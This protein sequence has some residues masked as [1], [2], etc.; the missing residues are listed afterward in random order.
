MVSIIIPNY[1]KFDLLEKCI[2]S[3]LKQNYTDIE[4][5]VVDNGSDNKDSIVC[6]ESKVKFIW[7]DKN[8]G[9]SKAVNIGIK[10]AKGNFLAIINN[11]TELTP[12]WINNILKAFKN[13][14]N[15][16]FITSKILSLNN[17]RIIDDVGDVILP[18]GKVYKIG[19]GEEDC[20][21][22]NNSRKIFGASGAASVYKREFFDIVGYFDEDFFAYLEDID[23]SFRANHFGLK[24]MYAPDAV[25]YH[26]GS[27]TTG[28]KFNKFT[29]YYLAQNT[30]NVIAK[31]FPIRVLIRYFPH[32]LSH[33]LKLQLYFSLNRLG[34]T[35]LKGLISGI[36]MINTMAK[37]RKEIMKNRR[38]PDS[39][40]ITMLKENKRLYIKSKAN[41]LE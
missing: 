8:E 10:Y 12:D 15:V 29:V 22:Y 20:G 30:I 13:N 23:L 32:I 21:Q 6:E 31:N 27:A 3:I 1:N 19:N 40:L 5:I 39:E 18:S 14:E 25:V 35:F 24:G 34:F 26:V 41:R 4:I 7:L 28:S 33:I 37:K 38:L 36:G 16:F 17:K 11:D 9:F 2:E